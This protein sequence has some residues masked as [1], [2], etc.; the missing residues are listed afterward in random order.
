MSELRITPLVKSLEPNEIFVFGS[1]ESGRHGLGAAKQAKLWG[2]KNGIA[3]GHCGQTFAIPT[4]DKD[5]RYTLS[6][7]KIEKYVQQFILYAIEHPELRF[8]VT[9]IGCGLAGLKPKDVAPMFKNA[10]TLKNV[11]L[12]FK[13]W[14]ELK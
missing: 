14:E 10:I 4:K 6:L 13:F 3:F 11:Y 5:V 7:S 2:A 8:F 12:P 9:E 1:N